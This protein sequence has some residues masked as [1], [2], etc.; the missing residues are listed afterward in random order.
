MS[1]APRKFRKPI[2]CSALS[3]VLILANLTDTLVPVVDSASTPLRRGSLHRRPVRRLARHLFLT[4]CIAR[5]L[6]CAPNFLMSDVP[7]FDVLPT[8]AQELRQR[9]ENL[10][11]TNEMRS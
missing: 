2:P 10:T 6:F 9:L 1:V 11:L 4:L 8:T 5:L 3:P 7:A